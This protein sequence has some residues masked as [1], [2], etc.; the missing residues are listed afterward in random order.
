[1][2][3]TETFNGNIQINRYDPEGL[4]HE[5]EENGE[6]VRFI[7]RDRE[8]I[9]EEKEKGDIRYI[10]GQDLLASDAEHARTYYHYASDEM[11]SITHVTAREEVLNRY[12]Y[13][14]WGNAL[15]CEEQV[16]NRFRFAGEQYD[17]IS[18]QYYLRARFYNPVIGR[19][20]QED[21]YRGDGLNLYA[22]CQNNPVYYI[23][24][25]GNF[26]EAAADRISNLI[27]EGRI[28]GKNRRKL[29]EYLSGKQNLEPGEKRVA[30]KLGIGS[31]GES[32][33][34]GSKIKNWKGDPVKIPEGHKMSP[35]DPDFSV[36]PI[37]EEGPFTSA[38][39]DAFLNGSPGDT[40]IAAH[41]RHQIPLRDGGV[42]DELRGPGHPFGNNHTKGSPSRHPGKSIFNA[43]PGGNALRSS[44]T[45]Q[46]FINK[47]K[48]LIEKKPGEW[49]DPGPDK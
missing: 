16:E 26:C 48:R 27:D 32:G 49:Y 18:Q 5:M 44:E 41:H 33:T 31:K 17:P 6:L 29:E 30:E 23:D 8:V 22:Y 10:R 46:S 15:T 28:K 14:A 47:G 20:T 2:T 9:A 43:E 42:I 13:D 35:R 36:P 12:E 34:E 37:Y 45:S 24:P 11:G 1:M 38:Q 39:R 7:F 19:F 25:T 4:R 40:H 21:S 3:K